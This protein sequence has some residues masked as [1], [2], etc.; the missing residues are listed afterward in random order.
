MAELGKRTKK[1][2]MRINLANQLEE[3]I[4]AHNIYQSS[5]TQRQNPDKE[6]VASLEQVTTEC[7]GRIDD[8]IRN[9]PRAA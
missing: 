4:W 6:V 1:N 8:Y 5:P 2:F 9:A 3:C 7:N